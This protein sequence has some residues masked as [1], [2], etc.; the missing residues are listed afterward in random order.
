MFESMKPATICL[1][2]CLLVL[3]LAFNQ[4]NT[5]YPAAGTERTKDV[6]G[7]E[8]D[9]LTEMHGNNQRA[10]KRKGTAAP[11]A[12]APAPTAKRVEAETRHRQDRQTLNTDHRTNNNKQTTKTT[13]NKGDNKN[14]QSKEDKKNQ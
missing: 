7:S 2:A 4:A 12:P 1:L 8:N 6:L 13:S 11:A 14:K 10:N 9:I 3:C 5:T